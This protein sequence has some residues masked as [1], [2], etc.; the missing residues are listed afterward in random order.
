MKMY[1]AGEWVGSDRSQSVINPFDGSIVDEVPLADASAI[2]RALAAADRAA[3]RLLNS[4]GAERQKIMERAGQLADERVEEIAQTISLELGKPIREARIEASRAGD[5]IRLAGFEGA[6]LYGQGLPLDAHPGA[7]KQRL[8]FTLREP[9]G[10]VVAI[11]PFNFPLLLVLHKIA[12]ALAAGNSV[13]LKP[14]S[15]TPL[16][17]LALTRVFL[18]AG[19][20]PEAISCITGSGST[21]G[22]RLCADE[23]VRKI[24]FTGST[25]V[26]NHIARVAGAK[27]LSLELGASCPTVILDDADIERAAVAVASGGYANAGQ[28]CISVQRAIVHEKIYADFLDALK[29]KVEALTLGNPLDVS[30]TLGPLVSESEAER[31]ERSISESVRRGAR[32]ITG[33]E[34]SGATVTPAIVADVDS[35]DALSQD[36]L[37]G[38]AVAVT[39]VSSLEEALIAA[40]STTYG[41]GAGLFTENL[42]K[43]IKFLRG[44]NA[45]VLH[46]NWTPLWRAD[47]M[48]YG[49]TKGSGIGK[50]GIR[51]AIA[52]MTEEKTIVLHGDV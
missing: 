25:G 49:G 46:M 14:A 10:V 44:V 27:K 36:E 23:R 3:L 19:L 13:I 28:V 47:L 24:T 12:P 42:S 21:V 15:H 45:G 4:T 26:G 52:E 32:L 7:G 29:P 18:D 40:N 20:D 51:S 37:F 35:S 39:S 38:P 6:Q 33:G 2:E 34:R 43:G 50:E 48:P 11:T 31:V 17:A 30:T 22:D 9:C 8:G 1:I 5:L 16:T 41:L